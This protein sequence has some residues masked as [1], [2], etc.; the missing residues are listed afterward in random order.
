[1]ICFSPSRPKREWLKQL[2]YTILAVLIQLA[3]DSLSRRI[4]LGL[5]RD[6]PAIIEDFEQFQARPKVYEEPPEW[7]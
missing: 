2:R 1:M 5:P 4:G 6:A 7:A 3:C